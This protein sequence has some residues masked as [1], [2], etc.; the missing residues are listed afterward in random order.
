[1]DPVIFVLHPMTKREKLDYT[2]RLVKEDNDMI[3]DL[4][5]DIFSSVV[6]DIKN[7][8]M[9]DGT[10]IKILKSRKKDREIISSKIVEMVPLDILSEI[11]ITA[12]RENKLLEDDKKK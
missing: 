4:A 11:G 8:K 2:R 3:T 6:A 9:P 10:P 7:W 5:M 1:M 12:M